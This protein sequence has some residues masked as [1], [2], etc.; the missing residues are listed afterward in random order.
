METYSDR[1]RRATPK[2]GDLLY[3]REGSYHGIAAEVPD[4]VEICMGQRM[5]LIRPDQGS[6]NFRFLRYWLNSAFVRGFIAGARE[7][8]GAP[9]INMPTIRN[10]LVPVP[11]IEEQ[12]AVAQ[13][14]G[15]LDDKIAINERIAVTADELAESLFQ[16][17]TR[18][19]DAVPMPNFLTPLLGGTPDRKIDAFWNGDVPWASAKDVVGAR[20]GVLLDTEEKITDLAAE[21]SRAKKLPI[22][23][24]V[25]TARGTVGVVAR[26]AQPTAINQSCYAFVPEGIPASVVFHLVRAASEHMLNVAH[27]TVFSTVNMKTFN[28]IEIPELSPNELASLDQEISPL[29]RTVEVHLRESRTLAA[30]RDALLPQLM[31][32]R[33]RVRDAEK[34]VEDAT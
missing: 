24:V 19:S 34:I 16:S 15:A 5:V 30:L 7:G 4:G 28:H 23:S 10:L 14:L 6:L 26:I 11:A 13:M 27:G 33:L 12:N 17:R 22:G 21:K 32:G 31:S 8:S 9:R 18:R 3:S 1:V 2:R 29:H 20:A 25:L